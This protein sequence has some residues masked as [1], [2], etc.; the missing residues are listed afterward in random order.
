MEISR[1]K[2]GQNLNRFFLSNSKSKNTSKKIGDKKIWWQKIGDKKL[3]TKKCDFLENGTINQRVFWLQKNQHQKWKSIVREN[4]Q[5]KGRF[6]SDR[7]FKR[8]EQKKQ[9]GCFG[10]GGWN[11]GRNLNRFFLSDSTSKN[12]SKKF[13]EKNVDQRPRTL[14]SKYWK[15]QCALFWKPH[16]R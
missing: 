7:S 5:K 8:Y 1:S 12:T 2:R 6:S 10:P 14:M 16:K 3:V 15:T 11:N 13:G 4:K 9:K